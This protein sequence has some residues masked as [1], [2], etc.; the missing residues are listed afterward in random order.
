MSNPAGIG[1]RDRKGRTDAKRYAVGTLGIVNGVRRSECGPPEVFQIR[2]S[3]RRASCLHQRPSRSRRQCDLKMSAGG[4]RAES[5]IDDLDPKC[6]HTK[7]IVVGDQLREFSVVLAAY[8]DMQRT[9]FA[10][11]IERI[12]G[13]N[14]GRSPIGK[15]SHALGA[16]RQLAREGVLVI[17]AQKGPTPGAGIGE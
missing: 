13:R 1:L 5:R 8:R 17:G 14:R 7:T 15:D 12:S 2:A 10:L 3:G 11:E 9:L 16:V 6:D 4:N